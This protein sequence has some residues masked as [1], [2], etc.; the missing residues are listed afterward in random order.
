MSEKAEIKRGVTIIEK[1][2]SGEIVANENV[3]TDVENEI[4]EK[5]DEH[6]CW[7]CTNGYP[8]KCKKVAN[9]KKCPIADYPFIIKGCQLVRAGY[10]EKFVVSD[11][12]NFKKEISKTKEELAESNKRFRKARE[13]IHI[14]YYD[15]E[16]LEEARETAKAR[17][18]RIK[19][20]KRNKK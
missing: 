5:Y 11:C 16:T 10:L 15:A 3:Q 13:S 1:K 19:K 6:L 7:Q 12:D 8:S 2:F 4:L 9:L 18:A 14:A 20:R 17:E